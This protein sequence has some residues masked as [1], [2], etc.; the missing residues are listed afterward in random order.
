M[1]VF[2]R[3]P[4]PL[5]VAWAG[6]V[7]TTG[8]SAIDYLV[9]DIYST[10]EDEEK[11]YRE[12]IIRMPDGW[13]CYD[14]PAY[15]PDVGPLPSK[16]NG[17]VTFGSFSNPVKINEYVVSVWARILGRVA[18]A[19]LLIKFRGI[20]SIANT[21]RLTAMFE[22]EGV[23]RSRL[24]LEGK[25]PHADLLA[26]YNDVDIALDPFPYSGG[27]TTYE[28]LWMGVPSA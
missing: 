25:S 22:A 15:A 14:P 20:N 3:K 2:A 5:Q 7:G 17:S 24:M 10:R 27:L 18:N 13:L 19:R 6:Y 28:A 11:F 4:A 12:K 9:S 23:D 16:R 1:L 26:R 21:D 8:L